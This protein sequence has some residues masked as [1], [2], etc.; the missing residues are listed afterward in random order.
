MA[1]QASR[2]VQGFLEHRAEGPAFALAVLCMVARA[3][4]FYSGGALL[5][6]R[7]LGPAGMQVFNIG[8]GIGLAVGCELLGSIAGRAWQ[9]NKAEAL[10]VQGRKGLSRAERHSLAEHFAGRARL[11]FVFMAIGLG[12]SVAAAFA[13][14]WTETGSRLSWGTLG[15]IVV[16]VLLVA[17]VA[18]LGIFKESR[19]EDASEI[20]SAQAVSLRAGIVDAAGKRIA[21]GTHT[22][23]DVRLVARA[24]PRAERERFEAALLPESANDPHWNVREIAAWLGCDTGAG[25][26]QIVRKLAKLAEHGAAILRDDTGAYRVPRSVVIASFA[27]DFLAINGRERE[28]STP[29]ASSRAIAETEPGHTQLA[30]LDASRQDS[31]PHVLRPPSDTTPTRAST[32]RTPSDTLA[33]SLTRAHPAL[34]RALPVLRIG[35]EHVAP[36]TRSA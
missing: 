9:L 34:A 31:A 13:F 22:S 14:M 3:S 24:L 12:A 16:T 20:A 33:E 35:A 36:D 30:S 21:A 19:G 4:Q 5:L 6:A 25:R 26:R 32:G 18:Y 1:K 10:E 15:N 8:S 2:G 17:V 29:R 23:Q 27:D 11:S 28:R 7:V